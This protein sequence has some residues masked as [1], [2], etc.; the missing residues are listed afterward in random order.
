MKKA[1]PASHTLPS[2]WTYAKLS[3]LV[4]NYTH[5][6]VDGP[7]G[8][9][10]HVSEYLEEGIPIVRIQNVDR[11]RFLHKNIRYISSSKAQELKRHNCRTND[12]LITKLGDPLGKACIVPSFIVNGIIVA[13]VVRMRVDEENISSKFVTFCI[14]SPAIINQF[15]RSKGTTRPRVNLA[16]IREIE[17]PCAPLNEQRRIVTKI[18]ELFTKLDEGLLC[19]KRVQ[20]LLGQYRQSVLKFAFEGKLT[21]AWRDEKSGKFK[22]NFSFLNDSSKII[23]NK[24]PPSSYGLSDMTK[25]PSA[26]TWIRLGDIYKIVMGQSPKGSYYNVKKD[27]IPL[28][29]GPTEFGKQYPIPVQWTTRITKRAEKGDLLLCVRGST[30]GRMNWSDQQYCIGR[31]L[32]ALRSKFS[33]LINNKILF[34]YLKAKINELLSNTTGSTFPNLTS[35]KLNEFPFPL[36][37]P[38]EQILIS[39]ELERQFSIL[40]K[41]ELI[42]SSAVEYANSLRESVLKTAFE[43]KLV[44]QDQNDEPVEVLLQKIKR[45]GAKQATITKMK[46]NKNSNYQQMRLI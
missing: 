7:F 21:E 17:I 24:S 11:N 41:V 18:E 13:D 6:I 42:V 2:G 14:N 19:L 28:L 23:I 3:D 1:L 25:L 43:G 9:D 34:F 32:A 10:L 15:P 38:K 12:I 20:I 39:D 5:D 45:N 4:T 27:G 8:S 35:I 30:T 40:E 46:N 29:N 26:W 16:Q 36:M 33:G 22:F 37:H 44:P 31:G